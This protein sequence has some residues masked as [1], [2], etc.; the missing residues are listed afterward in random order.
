[1]ATT[2]GKMSSA[3]V[4]SRAMS[5]PPCPS[6]MTRQFCWRLPSGLALTPVSGFPHARPA[7]GV[8]FCAQMVGTLEPS[9][10]V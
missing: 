3:T 9:K 8:S 4:T 5:A 10:L 7:V 2:V 6:A 1:M